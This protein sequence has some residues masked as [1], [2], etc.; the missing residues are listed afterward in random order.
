MCNI[1]PSS[2]SSRPTG[3]NQTMVSP[4]NWSTALRALREAGGTTQEGWAAQTGRGRRTVQRWERGEAVPKEADERAILKVCREKGLFRAYAHGPLCGLSV[5]PEWLRD[6]LAEARL[7]T[8]RTRE[9][10]QPEDHAGQQGCPGSRGRDSE[11]TPLHVPDGGTA[12]T[13]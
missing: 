8:F 13:G 6:M 1:V 12:R 10:R 7:A 5:T 11:R 4:P 3:A 2:S 9:M